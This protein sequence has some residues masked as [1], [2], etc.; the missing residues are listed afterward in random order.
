MDGWLGPSPPSARESREALVV[1]D[2]AR[3]DCLTAWSSARV[4]LRYGV[5]KKLTGG[6]CVDGCCRER[7]RSSGPLEDV[8]RHAPEAGMGGG[9]NVQFVHRPVRTPTVREPMQ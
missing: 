8:P 9:R 2:R 7:P 1:R 3:A 6:I 4:V 5:N